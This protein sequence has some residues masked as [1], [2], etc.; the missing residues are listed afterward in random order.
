MACNGRP[1][2]S[3]IGRRP[4]QHRQTQAP[5]DTR[6]ET[7]R[8]NKKWG[9]Q[10]TSAQLSPNPQA[11]RHPA[12]TA[13]PGH[14]QQPEH[15]GRQTTPKIAPAATSPNIRESA[16]ARR[17]RAH[18]V[19]RTRGTRIYEAPGVWVLGTHEVRADIEVSEAS[20]TPL[21]PGKRW[22]A[23]LHPNR[24]Q[25]PTSA[26]RAPEG[27]SRSVRQRTAALHQT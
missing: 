2:R 6:Q 20:P 26:R 12:A 10:N 21:T 7:S 19:T 17:A 13:H 16:T 22:V 25:G 3:S 8:T 4:P 23:K 9:N 27:D 11:H 14:R 18:K 1:R 5:P 15:L 24:D